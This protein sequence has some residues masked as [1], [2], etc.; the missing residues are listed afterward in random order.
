MFAASTRAAMSS[1]SSGGSDAQSLRTSI[2]AAAA[3]APDEHLKGR[4]AQAASEAMGASLRFVPETPSPPYK[5][6]AFTRRRRS[7][8]P[9]IPSL[10]T[11][12]KADK[13]QR[14]LRF[15]MEGD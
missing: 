7:R 3:A 12:L 6:G 2:A 1:V 9:A 15:R 10:V 14:S 5:R 4:A 11:S 8:P 13:I